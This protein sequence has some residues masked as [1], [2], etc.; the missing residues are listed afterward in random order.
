MLSS[1]FQPN[2]EKLTLRQLSGNKNVLLT[3]VSTSTYQ[4]LQ[5]GQGVKLHTRLDRVPNLITRGAIPLLP[6]IRIHDVDRVNFIF[7]LQ[8]K[9]L[10]PYSIFVW[11]SRYSKT[12]SDY[13]SKH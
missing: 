13:F 3:S 10:C 9:Y 6:S 8:K 5:N 1:T 2:F 11:I 7:Y 12:K 4:L